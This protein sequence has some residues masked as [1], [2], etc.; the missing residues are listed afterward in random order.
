MLKKAL[1]LEIPLTHDDLNDDRK[2]YDSIRS[3]KINSQLA[4]GGVVEPVGTDVLGYGV[5]GVCRPAL[6]V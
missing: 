5:V 1:E 2:R 6:C 3:R 4:A